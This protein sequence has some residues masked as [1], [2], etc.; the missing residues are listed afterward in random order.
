[1][2][3]VGQGVERKHGCHPLGR[4]DSGY[5]SGEGSAM[6]MRGGDWQILLV[7]II[8]AILLPWWVIVLIPLAPVLLIMLMCWL[9][10]RG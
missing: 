7:S 4:L 2:E 5:Q 6:K 1:V 8:L 10:L 3:E 9:V